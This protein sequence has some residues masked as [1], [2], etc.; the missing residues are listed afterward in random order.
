MKVAFLEDDEI[1]RSNYSDLL[2]SEG[3]EVHAMTTYQEALDSI[4]DLEA[5][6]VLLDVAL[7]D[8]AMAG[9]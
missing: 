3:Y 8:D 1:I 6:I 5:D 4:V 2:E 7:L 9:I